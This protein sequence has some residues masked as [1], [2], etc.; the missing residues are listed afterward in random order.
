M[1]HLPGLETFQYADDSFNG[2]VVVTAASQEIIA[3]YGQY[4]GDPQQGV[5]GKSLLTH[6]NFIQKLGRD[7]YAFRKGFPCVIVMLSQRPDPSS[8]LLVWH[9]FIP[10][11]RIEL[12]IYKVV[13]HEAKRNQC[14]IWYV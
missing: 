14:R 11:V 5:C 3:A 8:D 6:L 10:Y 2:S 9:S 4:P 7:A 12:C 1:P 13:Q